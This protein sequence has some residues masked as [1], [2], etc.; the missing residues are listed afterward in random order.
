MIGL[1]ETT[2]GLMFSPKHR[3]ISACVCVCVCVCVRACVCA[4]VFCTETVFSPRDALFTKSSFKFT[5]N[6]AP[7]SG[8]CDMAPSHGYA[9][10]TEFNITC[11][12]FSDQHQPLTYLFKA[13]S[14]ATL[15]TSPASLS[16]SRCTHL[17]L[18]HSTVLIIF[19]ENVAHR[20]SVE[21]VFHLVMNFSLVAVYNSTVSLVV[22]GD[23]EV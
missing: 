17:Q 22:V 2:S 13:G 10:T 14:C 3:M 1:G 15:S 12:P 6:T 21:F 8:N 7:V 5:T 11:T 19:D 4:C 23:I 18:T 20:H 16:I 9:F